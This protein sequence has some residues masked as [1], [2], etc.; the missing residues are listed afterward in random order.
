MA[1]VVRV[2]PGDPGQLPM[3]PGFRLGHR[4]RADLDL[5]RV[6]GRCSTS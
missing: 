3:G 4:I 1:G 5:L 6:P 2:V